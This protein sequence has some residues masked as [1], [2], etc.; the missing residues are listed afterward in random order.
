[1]RVT[2]LHKIVIVFLCLVLA[3]P[4]FGIG[5]ELIILIDVFGIELLL[6]SLSAYFW[7]YWGFLKSKLEEL[8]PYFFISPAKDILRCP[9]LLAHAVPGSMGLFIFILAFTTVSI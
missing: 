3:G 1:M 2:N 5:L 8:D 6:F 7:V 4:E 9:A